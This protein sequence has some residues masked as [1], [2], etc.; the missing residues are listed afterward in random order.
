MH[1]ELIPVT[2]ADV[3]DAA[4]WL[5]GAKANLDASARELAAART[6]H[7]EARKEFAVR[8]GDWVRLRRRLMQ[9]AP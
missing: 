5:A 6:A 4:A 2:A 7:Q 1:T 3:E 9:E 8:L